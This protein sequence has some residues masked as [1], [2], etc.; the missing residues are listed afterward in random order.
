M[1]LA[2]LKYTKSHEWV[3]LEGDE[4]V[5][6]IT[7]HAQGELGDITFI[8]LPKTGKKIQQNESV[9]TVE[10]VKAASEIYSPVSGE[11]LTV[12]ETLNDAPEKINSSPYGEGWIYR[13]KVSD[14]NELN[15]LMDKKGYDELI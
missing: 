14:K 7:D 1:D 3:R 8:D 15:A 2:G 6:G 13:V 4:A 12:N 10:S 5:V 9:A 11:I